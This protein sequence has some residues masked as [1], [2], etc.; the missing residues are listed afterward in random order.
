MGL[1]FRTLLVLLTIVAVAFATPFLWKQFQFQR[2]K[3]YIDC[4]LKSLT[5]P[6]QQR[7]N[8]IAN[9]VLN[10]PD[11]TGSFLASWKCP[12]CLWKHPSGK[13]VLLEFSHLRSIPGQSSAS[14]TV[15][16]KGGHLISRTEFP[17]GWR[18]DVVDAERID[19]ESTTEFLF[20]INSKSVMG[21]GGVAKQ[22]YTI[23]EDRPFLLRLEDF[24]GTLLSNGTENYRI[25]PELPEQFDATLLDNLKSTLPAK[26]DSAR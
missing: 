19:P 24:N 20:V 6:E 1:N 26:I 17:T 22:F 16:A 10:R 15:I 18:I 21:R 8:S 25:G 7:F 4:D 13:L 12:C 2:L 3:S 9:S 11:D 23:I 14:V 5:A